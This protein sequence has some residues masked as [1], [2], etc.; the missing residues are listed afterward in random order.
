[1]DYD[2]R[3]SLLAE[4]SND[5]TSGAVKQALIGRLLGLRRADPALFTAGVLEPLPARGQRL[6][7]ILAFTRRLDGRRVS[8][9]TILRAAAAVT[10]LGDMPDA[11]WWADTEVRIN[12]GWRPATDLFSAGP[13]FIEA[14]A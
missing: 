6:S 3:A 2:L 12:D 4:E 13:V 8:V 1:V 7:H 10:V 11:D 5:W 9:A 14:S